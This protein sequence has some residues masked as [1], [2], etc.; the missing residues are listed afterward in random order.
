MPW[1][2]HT[3]ILFVL[4]AGEV[5]DDFTDFSSVSEPAATACD[6]TAPSDEPGVG[7]DA[8]GTVRDNLQPFL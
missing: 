2:T 5:E 4:K 6:P 7:D 3:A 8:R 1:Q